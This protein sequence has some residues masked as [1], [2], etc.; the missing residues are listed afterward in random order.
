MLKFYWGDASPGQG[1]EGKGRCGSEG[2]VPGGDPGALAAT[3]T[4]PEA[5]E[6]HIRWPSRWVDLVHGLHW[7]G[8]HGEPHE[9]VH[10]RKEKEFRLPPAGTFQIASPSVSCG[11]SSEYEDVGWRSGAQ[12]QGEGG[13]RGECGRGTRFATHFTGTD[14]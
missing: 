14:K 10:R 8:C 13:H 12:S 6:G 11:V 1:D 4:A 2:V 5:E 7:K 9:G 3:P